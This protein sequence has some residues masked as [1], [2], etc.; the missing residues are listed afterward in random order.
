MK[1]LVKV[2]RKFSVPVNYKLSMTFN[3]VASSEKEAKELFLAN[4]SKDSYEIDLDKKI[5]DRGKVEVG[6]RAKLECDHYK[7]KYGFNRHILKY[8]MCTIVR[9]RGEYVD[10]KLDVIKGQTTDMFEGVHIDRITLVDT[11]G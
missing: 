7:W 10:V 2:M 6:G 8:P 1:S 5:I 9:V 11:P 4:Y 3:V